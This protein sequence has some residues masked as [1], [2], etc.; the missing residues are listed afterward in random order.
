MDTEQRCYELKHRSSE[1]SKKCGL[2]VYLGVAYETLTITLSYISHPPFASTVPLVI[3][4]C[5]VLGTYIYTFPNTG[6]LPDSPDAGF[7]CS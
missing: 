2:N 4:N 7:I 3:R 1:Q 5:L 6:P